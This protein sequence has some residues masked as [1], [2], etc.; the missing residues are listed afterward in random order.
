MGAFIQTLQEVQAGFP[1]AFLSAANHR[2]P[3]IVLKFQ[4]SSRHLNGQGSGLNHCKSGHQKRPLNSWLHPRSFW[5]ITRHLNSTTTLFPGI[6]APP[7]QEKIS[8][9]GLARAGRLNHD[10]R[11]RAFLRQ[12]PK[13][14]RIKHRSSAGHLCLSMVRVFNPYPPTTVLHR[15]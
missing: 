7:V 15:I 5:R 11:Q 10:P 8:R 4:H 2:V 14:Y 6:L 12:Q 3:H 1:T 9:P 13:A